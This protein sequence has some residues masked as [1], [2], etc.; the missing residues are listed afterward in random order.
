MPQQDA[1]QIKE[2]IIQFLSIRGPSLPIHISKEIDMSLLFASAFLSELL[3][4]R[5]VKITHMKVGSS[6]LH[7]IEGQEPRLE[8][9]GEQ[10][11]KSKEKDAFLRLRERKF[12][13]DSE[14]EPAIRVALRVIK[15]FAFPFNSSKNGLVWRY[16]TTNP[17]D[18][19]EEVQI[20]K[21]IEKVQ[22][23]EKKESVLD[24]FNKSL[25]KKA[26]EKPLEKPIEKSVEKP[27]PN[28]K[29]KQAKK[30]TSS[31][32]DEKFFNRVKEYVSSKNME[33]LD[34]KNF[35]KTELLLKLKDNEKELLLVAYNK[36]RINEA[37]IIKAHKKAQEL[38]IPYTILS[39]GDAP[40]KI[41]GLLEAL[42]SLDSIHKIE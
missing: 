26:E 34:I 33:I 18:Y 35:N 13:K 41:E 8:K 7:F 10:F 40:K 5:K 32:T 16:F 4:E 42:K 3:A 17:A 27:A 21:P 37:D 38:K 36:K 2:R 29:K 12:L 39:L 30:K 14:Q 28:T 19:K 15:D 9:F 25:E 23:P 22:Q 31:K 6:S 24:I 20:I 1:S 11:L